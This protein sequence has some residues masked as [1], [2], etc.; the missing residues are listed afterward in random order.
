ML[1]PNSPCEVVKIVGGL[2]LNPVDGLFGVP[3]FL[4]AL[5][6]DDTF[7]ST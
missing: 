3:V 5:G 4:P 7:H 6:G 2:L 1:T